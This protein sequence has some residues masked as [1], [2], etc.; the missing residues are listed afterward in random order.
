MT[1]VTVYGFSA[2]TFVRTARLALEEKGVDYVLEPHMPHDEVMATLHPFGKI[3]AFRHSEMTLFETSAIATYVDDHFD[4][5]ALQPADVVGRARMHQ[6]I[7]AYNDNGAP[8]IVP[9][10]VHRLVFDAPDEALIADRTPKARKALEVFDG[11]LAEGEWLTG[12]TL[13]L[14]DLFLAPPV[15]YLP[16]ISEGAALLDGLE[17]LDRWYR[18]ISARASFTATMPDIPDAA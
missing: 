7:S 18:A 1:D 2:S 9:I 4:G 10:I 5:P 11:A 8:S 14:A 12:D 17:N 15:F 13:T 16:M 6:W 3:P